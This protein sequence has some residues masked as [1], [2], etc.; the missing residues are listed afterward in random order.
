MT[1]VVGGLNITGKARADGV[2]APRGTVR[3]LNNNG[4]SRGDNTP[5]T[6]LTLRRALRRMNKRFCCCPVTRDRDCK[7]H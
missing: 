6:V 5:R 7:C 4:F 2:F 1:L 3:K